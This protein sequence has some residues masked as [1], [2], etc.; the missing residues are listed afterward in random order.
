MNARTPPPLSFDDFD[1]VPASQVV[2]RPGAKPSTVDQ[3]RRRA[4]ALGSVASTASLIGCSLFPR[5]I[6]PATLPPRP[7]TTG[8]PGTLVDIGPKID[9]GPLQRR[10]VRVWLPPGY[11]GSMQRYSVLYAHDGQAL[12]EPSDS[13]ANVAWDVD[14]MLASLMAMNDIWPTVL[15]AIDNGLQD[16]AREFTPELPLA[17]IGEP[18]RQAVPRPGNGLATDLLSERYL[19]V[20]VN[21][22]K[23]MVDREFRTRPGREDTAMIGSS[24]GG[25]ISLYGLCRYPQIFGSAACLSTHWPVTTNAQLLTPAVDARVETVAEAFRSW[26]RDRLPNPGNHRFYFDHG[27]QGLDSLYPAHQAKVDAIFRERGYRMH[28]DWTT[29]RFPNTGHDERFWKA[30][31][32][33][34]LSFLLRDARAG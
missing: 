18:L 30:R 13:L 27:T 19:A 28:V 16:R 22:I 25:L 21:R 1:G 34:P 7:P 11:A 10:R 8:V 6:A 23:P 31:L 24:M 2:G 15:V 20:L 33:V 32:S 17:S 3:G 4:L 29:R 12:I 26:L 14:R 5:A 9:F